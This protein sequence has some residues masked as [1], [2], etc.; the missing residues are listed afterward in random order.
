MHTIDAG[1]AYGHQLAPKRQPDLEMPTEKADVALF[2]DPPDLVIRV[3][4]DRRQHLWKS[5]LAGPI[6]TD[7]RLQTTRFVGSF[8]VVAG[9]PVIEDLLCPRRAVQGGSFDNSRLD[10]AGE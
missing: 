3:V 10:G 2:L 4:L 9:A 1:W 7:W 6:A 8:E 5:A